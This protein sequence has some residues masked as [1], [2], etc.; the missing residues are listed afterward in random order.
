M[1]RIVPFPQVKRTPREMVKRAIDELDRTLY[2]KIDRSEV[3]DIAG[4]YSQRCNLYRE[5]RRMLSNG[6]ALD[7][8]V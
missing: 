6:G 2:A 3:D 1:A 7:S 5:L 4:Q 8:S